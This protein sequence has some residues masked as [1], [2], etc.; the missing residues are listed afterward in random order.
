MKLT[1]SERI[2]ACWVKVEKHI[3]AEIELLR[4]KNDAEMDQIATARL[5]GRIFQ[6]KQ[7]LNLAS[8]D[9]ADE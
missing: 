3:K 5:R 4:L 6:L 7:L 2:S 1:D 8:T 9:K